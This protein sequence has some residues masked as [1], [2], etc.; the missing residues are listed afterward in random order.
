MS[1]LLDFLYLSI[2]GLITSTV[3]LI[4]L[5][6]RVRRGHW[7]FSLVYL[8]I[9]LLLSQAVLRSALEIHIDNS[10][11]AAGFALGLIVIA[12][13]EHWN[14]IGQVCFSMVLLCAGN[15]LAYS[16]YVTFYSSLGPLSLTFSL[17]LLMLIAA[18]LSLMVAH[19]FEVI[20]VICRIV[21][22]RQ[23][24]P[25]P[26]TDY[27]PKVSLHVP[28]YNEPPE[29]VID[30]LNALAKLDYPNYEVIMID[31]N[32]TDPAVWR[33]VEEHC[34]TLGF[35]FFHLDNWPGFKSGALN[36]ALTQIAPDTEIVGVI[37][38]DYLVES[39]YLR[40]LVG[41]F[42]NDKVAFVQTPQ[43][44]RD[45]DPKDRYSQALYQSYQYFFKLSMASRNER[46]GIIFTGTMGLI[47][48]SVLETV[49]GW[50][51]WCITED[52]EIALKILNMGYESVFVDKT[53]GR[54]VMPLDF[55]GLKK[56]RFRWAFGGMQ[57]LRMHWKKLLPFSR[58]FDKDSK[59][60]FGQ[61][62]DYWSGGLQW[63]ND[64]L[65]FIF[66]VILITSAITFSLKNSVFLQPIA[67]TVIF[68]PF[69]FIVFGLIKILW[70]LR[71][72][73]AC[74]F[75][76]AHR[77][78]LVLLSLTWVVT[79]A[80]VLGLTKEHGVFLRTP[81]SK[82]QRNIISTL[83]AVS[84][85]TGLSLIG[86]ATVGLLQVRAPISTT[87]VLLSGLLLW[88]SYIYGSAFVVNRWSLASP[89]SLTPASRRPSRTTGERFR[90]MVSDRRAS[91][92]VFG[93]IIGLSML[94]Y[95]SVKWAPES[96]VISRTNPF[97]R[98]V[99]SHQLINNPPEVLVKAQIFM[100]EDSALTK[101][102]DQALSLWASNGVLRD[103]NYTPND[104]SD[105]H[106]W[107]GLD[108]IRQRYRQEYALRSY[109]TLHHKD[110][111]TVF[112]KNEAVIVND[113]SAE[114]LMDGKRQKVFL[115]K[116]DRW[117]FRLIDGEWKIVELTV[118]RTPR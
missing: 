18:A 70:A 98:P 74:S 23:F 62:Y 48:R 91:T 102:I 28:A 75:R 90:A 68:I 99:I 33:P 92:A 100:E 16:A 58:L 19:T 79:M 109:V 114:I 56:Q 82:G 78:F 26:T 85:E 83:R 5:G 21:W 108:E 89:G 107:R 27:F 66:T 52:A 4:I 11:I 32:T 111:A 117:V 24:T 77:A 96:E 104:P 53:Y 20:D 12:L 1:L 101:N 112:E 25:T 31:D 67:D 30:T 72:R 41:F 73:L 71:L 15:Y 80:C 110:I 36:Y 7:L 97:N 60:S 39:S 51:E 14:A 3:S 40:E 13:T 76:Q 65:A 81:K 88:Q 86:V 17:I 8:T 95:F 84:K 106:V 49:G 46:N 57:V 94:Y 87:T 45:F 115:S 42:R 63:L 113:L 116:G 47:R 38:S 50:D 10:L 43:D 54:G 69:V 35:K 103:A 105:D 59:L 34:K 55:E 118:N 37:D 61:K 64:P 6:H 93:G 9:V 2:A 29:M 44:Y 22:R